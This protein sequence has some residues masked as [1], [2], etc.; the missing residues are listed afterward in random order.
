MH[1][2]LL[3]SSSARAEDRVPSEKRVRNFNMRPD[4]WLVKVYTGV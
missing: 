3:S 2:L 1:F 4:G